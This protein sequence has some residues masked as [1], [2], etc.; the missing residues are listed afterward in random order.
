[1]KLNCSDDTINTITLEESLEIRSFVEFDGHNNIIIH[2]NLYL[3]DIIILTHF[4]PTGANQF[5]FV[6]RANCRFS[7]LKLTYTT[8]IF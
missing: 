7:N 8:S 5:T 3:D 1:M 4:K 6:A 2:G